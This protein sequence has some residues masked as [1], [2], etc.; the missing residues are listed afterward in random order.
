[1]VSAT[2][3][4]QRSELCIRLEP[5]YASDEDRVVAAGCSGLRLHFDMSRTVAKEEAAVRALE[6]RYIVEAIPFGTLT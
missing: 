5:E 1:M 6:A 3:I 2:V 4:H